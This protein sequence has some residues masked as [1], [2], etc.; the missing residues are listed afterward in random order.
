MLDEAARDPSIRILTAPMEMSFDS[1]GNFCGPFKD[2][3]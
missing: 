3:M 2:W 1:Q